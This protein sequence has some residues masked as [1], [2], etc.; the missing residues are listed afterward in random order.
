MASGC[1]RQLSPKRGADAV[2]RD[3]KASS[4]EVGFDLGKDAGTEVDCCSV[5][6]E[7]VGHGNE[8]PV[9]LGLFFVEEANKFV[10]LLN[11]FEWFDKDGLPGGR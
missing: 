11:G 6:T 5:L 9:D 1:E 7:C 8:N 3:G 4:S 10:I 2:E